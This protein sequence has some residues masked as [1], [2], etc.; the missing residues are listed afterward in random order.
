MNATRQIIVSQFFQ[1]VEKNQIVCASPE[2]ARKTI[3]EGNRTAVKGW[4]WGL[5]NSNFVTD[6][7]VTLTIDQANEIRRAC[8]QAEW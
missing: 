1:R 2:E 4:R 7:G 5:S 6:E 8:S 3:E